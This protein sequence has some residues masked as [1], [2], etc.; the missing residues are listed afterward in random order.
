MHRSALNYVTEWTRRQ[1]RKPL[2]IRGARQV[3][4]SFLVRQLAGECFENLVEINFEQMPDVA[5]F[6]ASKTPRT[7]LPLLEA[8]FNAPIK[9][10]KTLLFLDEIQAA[11]EVFAALRYF[12][13]E[14]PGLHVIAA[15]SLL[16]FVLREHS[17]SMPVGRIEYLHLGPMT[18]EEFL[19]AIGRDKL[20]QWLVNFALSDP[21][22]DGMHQDLMSLVRRYCVV[23]G[24]PEAVAA[25]AQ[26]TS[27]QECEQVQQSILFTYRDDFSKYASKVQHRRVDKIF[28]KLP[29]LV[30]R[31]FMF[32]HVDP[33]ERSRELGAAFELLCL[34]RV[35]H[36][37]RH[38]HG[39]GVPLGA[40]A[41][42]RTF[43][44]LF[45]DV[46]LLCRACGLRVLDVEKAGDPMLVNA[47]AV[48]EQL[49]GQHL[50]L[51]GA[52]YEE[53]SLHCWMRDKPNSSAEVDYLL[54]HG[55]DV[56]P[57][58]VKAGATGRLKSLQL[59]LSEKNRDFG[60]RFNS[61]VPSLLDT[62]TPRVDGRTMPFRLLSLPFY[63]I[64]QARRLCAEV[65]ETDP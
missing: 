63:L 24:M 17:F 46:G 18:F 31:K 38:S 53:P 32:S 6:F 54:A 52:F 48:C 4:K 44:A 35:A 57:V 55:P 27:F 51:S 1:N 28:S 26:N 14:T 21:I 23:G 49:V 45:L 15:G 5:S 37:V 56:I 30:G 34:A 3:G 59:F 16:E 42:D 9:P 36:K 29:Q 25:F 7:I 60:L 22:P 13:E 43:K 61:D 64:D 20:Q 40:E 39:N 62:R 50:L 58:E 11:P 41:D 10:G 19:Q 8:R 12:H 47:G 65:L 33:E 2:V